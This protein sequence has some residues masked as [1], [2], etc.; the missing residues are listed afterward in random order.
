[1]CAGEKEDHS[2]PG[3]TGGGGGA[4]ITDGD[5]TYTH[6]GTSRT[7]WFHGHTESCNQNNKGYNSKSSQSTLTLTCFR[8]RARTLAR[9]RH[10]D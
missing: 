9:E 6:M 1:M 4:D 8:R 10:R 2:E 7:C 3:G 5:A